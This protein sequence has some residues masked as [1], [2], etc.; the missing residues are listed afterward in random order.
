M[1]NYFYILLALFIVSCSSDSK[2]TILEKLTVERDSLKSEYNEVG[3]LLAEVEL[4]ISKLDTTKR[5]VNVTV[6]KA[7]SQNFEHYFKVYG[8]VNADNNTSVYPS[9]QG[10][11]IRIYVEE[12]QSVKKGQTLFKIDSEILERNIDEVQTQRSLAKDV[13][14]KQ[15][16]LWDKN[17]GSEMDYL[18][19]KNNLASL[20]SRLATLKSQLGKTNVKAPFSGSIDQIFIKNGQ[21]VNP[22]VA[23]MRIVNLD[24]VYLKADIPE[25][26]IKQ[27]GKG[28]P[29]KLSFPSINLEMETTINETGKFINPANRTFA[30]RINLD[31]KNNM[32]YP[33][34]LGMLQIQDYGNDS[35]LIVPARLIQENAQGESFLFV[36]QNDQESI[37]SVIKTV[38][39]GTTYEGQTEIISGLNAGDLIIDKGARNVSNGQIIAI[40]E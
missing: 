39:V 1:K 28:S 19:A 22:Q 16:A 40:V 29:V 38:E 18:R 24:K 15:K 3:T 31:N 2:E 17:I 21:L 13:Y 11:V 37:K 25:N 27:I 32:L 35:A 6:A 10:E 8:A 26:Y 34:L 33:N 14:D 7:T 30:V 5:L 23:T 12:G 9:S 36:A 4:K 20:D